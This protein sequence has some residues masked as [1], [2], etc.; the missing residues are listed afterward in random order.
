MV[1]LQQERCVDYRDG[2]TPESDFFLSVKNRIKK[3]ETYK[4]WRLLIFLS[5]DVKWSLFMA[6]ETLLNLTLP[7]QSQICIFSEL[8]ISPLV[9]VLKELSTDF[10]LGENTP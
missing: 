10:S 1:N 3:K 4:K 8:V 5:V 9:L 7:T 6:W 2:R